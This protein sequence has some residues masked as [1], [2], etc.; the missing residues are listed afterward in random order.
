MNFQ[1]FSHILEK[2]KDKGKHFCFEATA[3]NTNKDPRE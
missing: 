3:E 1:R 2:E